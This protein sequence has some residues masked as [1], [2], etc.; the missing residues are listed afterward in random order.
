MA[1]IMEQAGG[2]ASCGMFKGPSETWQIGW[3]GGRG[4]YD[5]ISCVYINQEMQ[6][7]RYIY[8]H[9]EIHDIFWSKPSLPTK[10]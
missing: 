10:P 1:F 7:Y 6:R 9:I 2:S 3:K 4:P 8:I 5:M